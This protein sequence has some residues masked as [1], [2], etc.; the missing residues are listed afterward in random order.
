MPPR[1][2]KNQ[3]FSWVQFIGW[4][5][6]VLV[7]LFLFKGAITKFIGDATDTDIEF[8]KDGLSIHAKR[9]SPANQFPENDKEKGESPGHAPTP[10]ATSTQPPPTA[11]VTPAQPPLV[12]RQLRLHRNG[13]GLCPLRNGFAACSLRPW[14]GF[15][16]CSLRLWN[17]S[18]IFGLSL[19]DPSYDPPIYPGRIDFTLP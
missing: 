18:G 15:A 11:V 13:F 16:V 10:V 2:T 17:G 5:L 8:N 6:V 9:P 7:A 4:P 19:S 14:L 12:Q 3:D 1:G